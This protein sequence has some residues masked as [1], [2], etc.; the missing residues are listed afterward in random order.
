MTQPSDDIVKLQKASL[1]ASLLLK[2]MSNEDRLVLLCQLVKS[3]KSVGEI[4]VATGILQPTLSQQLT[5]FR[6]N[7]LVTTRRQGKHIYYRVTEPAVLAIMNV[8]YEHFCQAPNN[9]K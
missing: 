7:G 5:V 2:A 3:E 9:L 6:E 4:E 1:R 8:L